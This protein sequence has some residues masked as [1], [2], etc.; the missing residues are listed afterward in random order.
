MGKVTITRRTFLKAAAVTGAATALPAGM[1][2]LKGLAQARASSAPPAETV[3]PGRCFECHVQCYLL[4][5]VRD[6]RVIKVEG[7]PKG[8]PNRG[9][10]CSKGQANV[11]N[12]YSPER[13][14]YPFKR[15]RPKGELDPGW[16]R[17]SWDEAL[18]TIAS[19]VQELKQKYGARSLAVGQ[20]TGRYSNEHN[21][22]LKSTIGTPNN[23]GA[24]HICRGPM[25]ATV[26][27]TVG[28]HMRGDFANAG[29]QVYWG[30]NEAW[31]HA[32][33]SMPGAMDN[34]IGRNTKLLVIDPRYEHPLAHKADVYL[35]VRPGSDGALFMT[36]IHVILTE[37]LYNEEFCKKWTNGPMLVR[38]DNMELLREGEVVPGGDNKTFLTY[39][40]N[41]ADRSK[42]PT[43]MVWDTKT[44]SAKAVDTPG[45]DPA[46]FGSY[47]VAGIQCKTV[48]QIISERAAQFPP[49]K[50]AEICWIGSADKI[51]EAVRLYAKAPSACTDVGSF[52]YQGIEG[53]HTNTFQTIRAEV[54]MAAITGNINKPGAECGMPHWKWVVGQWKRE[55]GFRAMTP[56]GAPDDD[57]TIVMEGPHPE[58]P[59][60]NEFPMQ[61]G[62][63]AMHDCF[64]AMV[65]GK[66][67]PI[68][69]YLMIQGNPL[70]GWADDQ[71][72]VYE[73]LKALEFL[74]DMDWY[75]T[76]T[77]NLADIVLPAGQGPY[78][79]GKDKVIKPM[80]E[81]W[82][83]EE[84][85]VQI[86]KRLDPKWWPWKD[87]AAWWEWRAGVEGAN[88]GGA[89]AA[90]IAIER[91][92]PSPGLDFYT[93]TDPK[94]GKPIGFATPTGKIE[95]YSVI[96]K[97]RGVDP[98]PNYVE[99][100]Q[101]PYS[102]PEL[103]KQYPLVL[104]T[105]HRL[106]VF[107]HSTYRNNPFQRELY[108]HPQFDIHPDTA[109]KYG[110]KDGEWGWIETKMGRIRMIAYVTLGV[111]PN[112]IS[113][114][115]GW[116]QGCK[117][118]GL[119]GYGWDGANCNVLINGAERDPALGVA[120]LRSQL[121]KVYKADEPPFV[122]DPPYFGTTQPEQ[123]RGPKQYPD[124][125]RRKEG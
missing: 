54:V 79:R 80:F 53:G 31:A 86:G 4:V 78:E 100:V 110:I 90:G 43:L 89:R 114:A 55:G 42:R 108:P 29:C 119:P 5:H 65:T 56:W 33:W 67:Y 73:G 44:N 8:M 68:K 96:A 77:G 101:S 38:L 111:M 40:D 39:P 87:E 72:A 106:P 102:N 91:G 47:T 18:T 22:R 21:A 51:R 28:H 74:A 63:S 124:A 61:P 15:T 109:A 107:Y 50:T 12:L 11:Q 94:T 88:I 27:L 71:K 3:V 48:L 93:K 83:D 76:P 49:E 37:K 120:A 85:Y 30:R 17:I 64:E 104:T 24:S 95:L 105:G 14:N 1:L 9:A 57:F 20:G 98:M 99:P 34:L 82:S 121:C 103:A 118:L 58:E 45:V 25:A 10:L 112:V 115:H 6:G 113:M 36:F 62:M 13:L 81:R 41:I 35:P 52:G 19:K 70:G 26:C 117:E 16:V 116:W 59:A 97:Q 32:A 7:D 123:Y 75:I 66:P 2:S 84:Y 60:M 125:P 69:A 46:L 23:I 92:A 122:W